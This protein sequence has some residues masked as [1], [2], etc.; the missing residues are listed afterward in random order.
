MNKYDRDK[1]R[2]QIFPEY[3]QKQINRN[4]P[5]KIAE[6]RNQNWCNESYLYELIYDE[7]AKGGTHSKNV[8]EELNKQIDNGEYPI[9]VE[10]MNRIQ[11]YQELIGIQFLHDYKNDILY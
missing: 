8:I 7:E 2:K 1:I 6:H 11:A 9:P 5:R 10:L 3:I 4:I